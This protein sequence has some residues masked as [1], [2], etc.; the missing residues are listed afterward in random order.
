MTDLKPC[1]HCG[2]EAVRDDWTLIVRCRDCNAQATRS[3]WNN[4]PAE[5]AL[6]AE[7]AAANKRV[8]DWREDNAVCLAKV[9]AIRAE[10]AGVRAAWH[11]E[12]AR[13]TD[14]QARAAGW[15]KEAE[16]ARA[17]VEAAVEFSQHDWY[18]EHGELERFKATVTTYL[19]KKG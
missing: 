13:A 16:Q 3:A 12:Q 17:V 19:A 8:D 18:F 10:M 9:D 1:P 7:R 5:D 4:R 11:A 6:R 14:A 15:R 2:G